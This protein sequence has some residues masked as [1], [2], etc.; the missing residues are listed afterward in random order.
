[1]TRINT[2]V[3]L[4]ASKEPPPRSVWGMAMVML[5]SAFGAASSPTRPER[6]AGR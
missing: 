1:M 4:A 2:L 5:G 3:Q 6:R